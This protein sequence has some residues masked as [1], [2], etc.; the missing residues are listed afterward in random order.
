MF[1]DVDLTVATPPG[2]SVP[3][4]A[5]L[6]FGYSKRVFV[7]RG[8]GIFEPREVDTGEPYGDRVQILRGLAE[9][10]KVV[11]SGTFLVDSESRLTSSAERAH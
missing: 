5:V 9:G 1:I 7:D 6:D 2:L 4:D 11:A 3:A 10:E 8:N